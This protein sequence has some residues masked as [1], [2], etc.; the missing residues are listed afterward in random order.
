MITI[1]PYEELGHANHGW[2]NAHHHFSFARYYNPDRIGFG[3][4]RVINDD[5]IQPHTGFSPHP[6]RDMEIITYV[7]QGAITHED[8]QG[9]KGRTVAGDVQVMSAGT[10]IFHSEFNKEDEE[11]RIFQ[12]WI[13]PHT[14]GVTPQWGSHR[15]PKEAKQDGLPLL[16][17]GDGNAPL[18]IHQD[19]Y[20]YGGTLDKGAPI[21]HPIHHQAYLLVSEGTLTLD[22]K[23]MKKGD[24]AEIMDTDSIQLAT[25]DHVELLV[26]DVPAANQPTH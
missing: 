25:D 15:F 19:A 16:V 1:Y 9:N 11:T 4:L 24:G 20:I 14:E 12:I 17:S 6:H 7:R 23:S 8:N 21:D 2:L 10:G 3:T 18:S 5:I 26:I 22:G 13:E